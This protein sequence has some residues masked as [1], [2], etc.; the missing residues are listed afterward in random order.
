MIR[1]RALA[2]HATDTT[3][4]AASN[5]LLA[6]L[7]ARTQPIGG[8]RVLTDDQV[9][10]F[11]A[12]L[13]PTA[14]PGIGPAAARTLARLGLTTPGRIAATPL[15]RALGSG[16]GTCLH[17]H[18]QGIDPTPSPPPARGRRP[19]T[20]PPGAPPPVRVGHLGAGFRDG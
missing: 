4:A 3:T 20:A 18:A 2:T 13:P 10:G 9:T 14:L 7:A 15:Q 5:P 1:A 12:P 19:G 8:L 16:P 11:L 17:R 6:H